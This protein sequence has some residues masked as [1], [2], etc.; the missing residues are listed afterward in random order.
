MSYLVVPVGFALPKTQRAAVP[1]SRN[2]VIVGLRPPLSLLA[3]QDAAFRHDLLIS[4]MAALG[5]L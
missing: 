1:S 4:D 3:I 5:A 2:P